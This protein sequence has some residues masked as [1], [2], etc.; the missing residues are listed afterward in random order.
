[1]SLPCRIKR[2]AAQELFLRT[3]LLKCT[4]LSGYQRVQAMS[5][6]CW[7]FV[8]VIMQLSVAIGCQKAC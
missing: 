4:L 2:A 8:V 1:M 5:D 3:G 7:S 6:R